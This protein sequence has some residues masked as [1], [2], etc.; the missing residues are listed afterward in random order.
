VDRVVPRVGDK[1]KELAGNR[2][3]TVPIQCT[4]GS[5]FRPEP[6]DTVDVLLREADEQ[7]RTGARRV[8]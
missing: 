1:L 4:V 8:P 2:A 3:L 5:A 6:P 7:M